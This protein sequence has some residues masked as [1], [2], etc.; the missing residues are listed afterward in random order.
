MNFFKNP[1]NLYKTDYKLRNAIIDYFKETDTIKVKLD[2]R[3][4]EEK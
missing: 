3:F 1:V 2:G 4:R